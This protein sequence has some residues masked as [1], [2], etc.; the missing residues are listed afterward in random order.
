M[1]GICH[2]MMAWRG[3]GLGGEEEGNPGRA[4]VDV[5]GTDLGDFRDMNN[6]GWWDRDHMG[7]TNVL[8]GTK[9]WNGML[10]TK[11]KGKEEQDLGLQH[12]EEIRI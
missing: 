1:K 3:G 2:D 12:Q 5:E 6:G 9:R 4:T 10:F 7:G 11:E 8:E